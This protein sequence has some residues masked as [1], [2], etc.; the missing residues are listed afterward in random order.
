MNIWV[1]DTNIFLRFLLADVSEQ[2]KATLDLFERAKLR[3]ITVYVCS[4][5]MF[6]LDYALSKY[7][8]F[9]RA[10]IVEAMGRII[11]IP[12]FEIEDRDAFQAALVLY[13]KT[14][15][16]LVDCFLLAKAGLLEGNILS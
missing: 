13:G 12:Y 9:E 11:G 16:D 7:Y 14:N 5:I 2:H 8:K 4:A 10:D 15:F 6:E 3:E 1:A